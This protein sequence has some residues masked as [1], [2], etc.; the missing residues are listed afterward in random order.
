MILVSLLLALNTAHAAPVKGETEL[1]R[2]NC[3]SRAAAYSTLSKS[4]KE[5]LSDLCVQSAVYE[6]D[7]SA[8]Q[9]QINTLESSKEECYGSRRR[10][11]SP[12][13]WFGGGALTSQAAIDACVKAQ[14]DIDTRLNS[15]KENL[16]LAQQQAKVAQEKSETANS[17]AGADA[18]DRAGIDAEYNKL[19]YSFFSSQLQAADADASLTKMA[20]AVDRTA[21]GLYLRERMAGLLNSE[22]MC[23]TVKSCPA[24]IKGSDLN[25][26]VFN[27]SMNTS[28][29][30]GEATSSSPAGKGKTTR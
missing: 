11:D 23:K 10:L 12:S 16:K 8:I 13:T 18:K 24:G 6:R 3:N 25:K 9:T 19:R 26:D 22:A 30:D 29:K 5:K 15:L 14:K 27:G 20:A 4:E 1:D 28:V 17:G 2:R 21:M 7:A